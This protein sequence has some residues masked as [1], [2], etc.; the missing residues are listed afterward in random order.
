M[1]RRKE[2][3]FNSFVCF[4][5]E[6]TGLSRNDR[7]IEIGA[8]KVENGYLVSR[9]SSL[10]DPRRPIS[11]LITQITGISDE[12]VR[13]KPGI[14]ELLPS[15]YAYTQG[16]ILMAHNAPFDCGF[17][18]RAAE[19]TGYRFDQPVFD[20]LTFARRVLP[21]RVSYRLPDLTEDLKIPQETAHRAWCD[22]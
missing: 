22:A 10:V 21:N 12:M 6:T 16:Y 20:T 9:Y 5:F 8:V 7:I 1:I 19:G 11:P 17:L 13:G 2:P 4:D 3:D 14:E 18:T 15:F